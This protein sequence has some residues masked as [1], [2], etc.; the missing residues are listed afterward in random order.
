MIAT[1][2]AIKPSPNPAPDTLLFTYAKDGKF[3]VKKTYQLLKGE[4]SQ[5]SDR[6]FWDRLW[7]D[8]GLTPKLKIFVSR[9]IKGALLVRA[10]LSYRIRTLSPLCPLCQL[11]PETI[12]HTLFHC[13]FAKRAWLVSAL[14]LRT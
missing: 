10:I 6:S 13:E 1:N 8:T 2:D 4:P 14:P 11:V 12:M 3:S 9:C 5:H 7:K